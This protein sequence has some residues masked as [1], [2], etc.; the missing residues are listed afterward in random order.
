[1]PQLLSE[2][3]CW[4]DPP[5]VSIASPMAA[6]HSSWPLL[7]LQ[8][9]IKLEAWRE[10]VRSKYAELGPGAEVPAD[11]PRQLQV[12]QKVTAR[13]PITRQ[14]HDG[15]V[16]TVAANSYRCCPRQGNTPPRFGA[17]SGLC[18]PAA[19]VA[20]SGFS[21]GHTAASQAS[22]CCAGCN[23]TEGSWVWSSSRTST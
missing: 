9:R 1:M 23:L 12:G 5:H 14:L 3:V 7:W 10:K 16:L 4:V 13:H 19:C 21:Q 2:R 15:D 20:R 11:F 17:T 6:R 18:C 8:E 22:P